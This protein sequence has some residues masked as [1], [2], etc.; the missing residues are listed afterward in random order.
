MNK[1]IFVDGGRVLTAFFLVLW[2][3]NFSGAAAQTV[4]NAVAVEILRAEDTRDFDARLEKML[5]SPN[6]AVRRRAALAAGRIGDERAV[7]AL[8]QLLR[9]DANADVRE[10]AA[11]ALGEIESVKAAAA[12]IQT[13]ESQTEK[14][15]V[16]ARAVEAAGKIAA[17]NPNNNFKESLDEIILDTLDA[18]FAKAAKADRLT[19]L[20]GLTA[21]LRARP[22]EG[23][24][25]AVKFLS[26]SDAEI[27][28]VAANTMARLRA[29]NAD[30]Q[31]RALLLADETA[32]VRANSARA[33]GA[34]ESAESFNDLVLAATTD[35]DSR[36]RV[37]AIRSLNALKNE[38]AVE[39]LLEHGTELLAEA[40]RTK[41]PSLAANKSELLEVAAVLGNL[42]KTKQAKVLP[43]LLQLNET[44]EYESP[45][46][47]TALAKI[48]PVRFGEIQKQRNSRKDLRWQEVNAAL[49]GVAE[50]A[51]APDSE[52][53]KI[54][55][56]TAK[57]NTLQLINNLLKTDS[58]EEK[59]LSDALSAYAAFKPDNLSNVLREALKQ[60]SVTVR[61]SAAGLLAEQKTS[62]AENLKALSEAFT[63]SA[64]NDRTNNDAAL[65]ILDAL[66]KLDAEKALPDLIQASV[67]ED[68]L[69]RRK[70]LTLL[71]DKAY[72][73][74]DLA[75]MTVASAGEKRK[76]TVNSSFK[77]SKLGVLLN[78]NSDY[79]RALARRNGEYKAVLTTEKGV[80]TINLMPEDA[81]LT[82]DNFIKLANSNY[83]N[84]LTVHRVVANFVMQDGDPS[85]DGNGGPGWQIRCEI[86]EIPF[87]R[88]AVGM[89]L[90]G[91]D[92]G[93]SQWFVTH[94]NQPHL[95]GGYTVFGTI[96]ENDMQVV[97]A[98]VRGDK[99][100]NVK[101]LAS[102]KRRVGQSK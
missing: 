78:T 92:T 43:F 40:K 70:A 55:K 32:E 19:I 39:T 58:A 4:P 49:A 61:A 50:L 3:G 30:G 85:G 24:L 1:K 18:E 102:K 65:A 87:R 54:V 77:N 22:N 69:I 48:A 64:L 84:G 47:F 80:F 33:L 62:S 11:F 99:I 34:S 9:N 13:L 52:Q 25:I 79:A 63:F 76:L 5:T 15:N 56:E 37:A 45:E 26:N 44:L 98:V 29:K 51:S 72:E 7:D 74:N 57:N 23:E 75:Q 21:I 31:F 46:V 10:I 59:S 82:V 53:N 86:N 36:V 83:F 60:R 28:A 41:T 14:T 20:L 90:S 89:A 6:F 88:G 93:G 96:S 81:P 17:A 27:R 67:S 95:D 97:D 100:L 94:S 16:R 42:A 12:I 91:K 66:F 73:K 38:N 101:I 8:A 35:E 68:Y 2:L 71:A